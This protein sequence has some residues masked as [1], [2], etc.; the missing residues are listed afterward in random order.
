MMIVS[1]IYGEVNKHEVWKCECKEG[2][3]YV[4]TLSTNI[5]K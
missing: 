5:E 2:K 1:N 3:F 4:D